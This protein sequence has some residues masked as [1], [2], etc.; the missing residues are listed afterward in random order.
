M[1]PCTD[2]QAIAVGSSLCSGCA[3]AALEQ[4][5]RQTA[6]MVSGETFA[7]AYPG[8]DRLLE[9]ISSLDTDLSLST[10]FCGTRLCPDERDAIRG[11]S[12]TPQD[13]MLGTLQGIAEELHG[14]Y[15]N[16]EDRLHTGC[17]NL[18]GSG[19]GLRQNPDLQK[20]FEHTFG[21]S[22]KIPQHK[23]E[24]V[25]GAVLFALAAIGV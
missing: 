11:L 7:S 8:M 25:F 18:I 21:M 19:N 24:A 3:F 15:R 20:M 16:A 22:L 1:P 17:K 10:K 23:E 9:S 14:M 12:F 2:Q 4:F 5:F 6:E 13:F